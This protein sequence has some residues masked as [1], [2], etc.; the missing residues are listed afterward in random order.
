MGYKDE[1]PVAPTPPLQILFFRA[2][3]AITDFYGSSLN[4][5]MAKL[6]YSKE[7]F[8]FWSQ[9]AVF[10]LVRNERVVNSH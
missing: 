7:G 3:L 6:K 5:Y 9:I 8:L 4:A 10:I 1:N 2:V